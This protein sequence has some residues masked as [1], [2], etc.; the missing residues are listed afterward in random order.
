MRKILYLILIIIAVIFVCWNYLF[1]W[2]PESQNA[3]KNVENSKLLITG[4]TKH[5]VL[6]IMGQPNDSTISKKNPGLTIYYYSPPIMA[7]D[8]IYLYVNS[9]NNK[10]ERILLYE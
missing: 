6:N 3:R 8:G 10:L 5:E 4:M 9:E 2:S 1:K 7:S